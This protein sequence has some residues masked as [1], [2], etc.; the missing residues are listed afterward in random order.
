MKKEFI[1]SV[2]LLIAMAFW[3]LSWPLSKIMI[4]YLSPY[5]TAC[6]RFGLVALSFV[7]VM[8]YLHIP[9]KIPKVSHKGVFLTSIFNASYSILFFVGLSLGDAGSAGVI[10]TTLAPILASIIGVFIHHNS[11]LKREKIGLFLGLVSGVFLMGINHLSSLFTS[12]NIIF[13][14]AA[15]LW[16]SITLSSKSATSHINAI[17]L[18]FYSSF[19]SFIVFFPSFFIFGFPQIQNL[20]GIFWFCMIVVA[21]L[22][23]TFAT[24]IFYKGVNILGINKGGSFTLLVPIFALLFSCLILGEI[25]KLH[26]IIG[27]V[28]AIAAIYFINLFNPNHFKKKQSL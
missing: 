7:P 3:G 16:G 11:L 19:F 15:L 22:S 27:G 6:I 26:T 12:F 5:E 10:V 2:L 1:F 20:G 23:T 24:T 4:E 17:A 13:F 25:P 28:I 9:F 14:I 18:N 8:I 21:L